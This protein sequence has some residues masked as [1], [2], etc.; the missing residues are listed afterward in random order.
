MKWLFQAFILSG[1]WGL[2][3]PKSP[4]TS[5]RMKALAE[6]PQPRPHPGGIL[7]NAALTQHPT[8]SPLPGQALT[9]DCPEK[10]PENG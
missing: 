8:Y 7:T 10:G 1:P 2:S 3:C 4:F 5:S 9:E 6:L